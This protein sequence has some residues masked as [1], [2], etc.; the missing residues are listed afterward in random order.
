M[1]VIGDAWMAGDGAS[2]PESG[3]ADTL[4]DKYGLELVNLSATGVDYLKPGL[5]DERLAEPAAAVVVALGL[6]EYG[7]TS[8]RSAVVENVLER[9]KKEQPTAQVIVVGPFWPDGSPTPEALA[10]DDSVA[11][12]AGSLGLP[13]IDPIGQRW[14]TGRPQEAGNALRYI[15]KDGNPTQTGH[16]YV[17]GRLVDA[18]NDL[19]LLDAE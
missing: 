9:V 15:S 19:G 6:A 2:G 17:A 12:T 3:M 5:D 13:F 7:P 10:F 18:I 16:D 1:I 8:Y 11:V 4:A 14:I